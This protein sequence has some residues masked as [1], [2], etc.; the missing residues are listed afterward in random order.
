MKALYDERRRKAHSSTIVLG[1]FFNAR[2]SDR[3]RSREALYKTMLHDLAHSRPDLKAVFLANYLRKRRG[4]QQLRWEF[5]WQLPELV[6]M[7]HLSIEDDQL[8]KVEILIDALDE[9]SDDDVNDVVSSFSESLEATAERRNLKVCWS[10]RFYPHIDLRTSWGVE[11][12]LNELNARDIERYLR[13]TISDELQKAWVK[14]IPDIVSAADGIFLW[15]RLV[16]SR[17]VKDFSRGV[18]PAKLQRLLSKTPRND[19]DK[20]FLMIFNDPDFSIDQKND[21]QPI[22]DIILGSYRAL[23]L[24]ELYTALLLESAHDEPFLELR[25][26]DEEQF[27]KRLIS[28]SGGLIE[29]V[30]LREK[31]KKARSEVDYELLEWRRQQALELLNWRRQKARSEVDYELMELRQQQALELLKWRRQKALELDR[32]YG[33]VRDIGSSAYVRPEETITDRPA[34]SGFKIPKAPIFSSGSSRPT[35]V[36]VIHES[37]REFFLAKDGMSIIRAQSSREFEKRSHTTLTRAC[38]NGLA[39]ISTT[40]SGIRSDQRNAGLS[41]WDKETQLLVPPI[42][43]NPTNSFLC[44]YVAEYAISHFEQVVQSLDDVESMWETINAAEQP[45]SIIHGYLIWCCYVTKHSGNLPV[46]YKKQL[47]TILRRASYFDANIESFDT[48]VSFPD[49]FEGIVRTQMERKKQEA[50]RL[51]LGS[52]WQ[53]QT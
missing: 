53:R 51:N 5:Q 32:Y 12:R 41:V 38:F 21:F 49:R 36:Q 18:E 44:T 9:C 2:G 25:E 45:R 14:V 22:A 31:K 4:R 24:E 20:L 10:S 11:V 26:E 43:W 6:D 1:F 28:A 27:R 39:K 50:S 46:G 34:A 30:D 13:K 16:C 29:V 33:R 23:S 47:Q 40:L 17:I 48:A 3:E 42:A 37:V 8:E 52:E 15:A 19:L 35:R 7:F